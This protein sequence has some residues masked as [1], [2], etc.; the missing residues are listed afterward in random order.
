[1]G[2]VVLAAIQDCPASLDSLLRSSSLAEAPV[3]VALKELE[4]I[5]LEH[6]ANH[7]WDAEENE[8]VDLKV[9]NLKAK[10]AFAHKLVHAC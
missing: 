7:V 3:D 4:E 10:A 2:L 5:D 9:E 8:E 1:L 6:K